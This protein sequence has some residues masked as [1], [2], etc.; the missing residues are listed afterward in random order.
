M[1][2]PS[3]RQLRGRRKGKGSEA[4]W[5]SR[6]PDSWMKEQHVICYFFLQNEVGKILKICGQQVR[7]SAV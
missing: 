1:R 4:G 6:S 7:H 2:P 3:S 5:L